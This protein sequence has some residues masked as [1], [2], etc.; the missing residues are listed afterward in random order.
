MA[1]INGQSKTYV[2]TR[3]MNADD[4]LD[5]FEA[6]VKF[7]LEHIVGILSQGMNNHCQFKHEKLIQ[8]RKFDERVDRVDKLH[9]CTPIEQRR[10]SHVLLYCH[11]VF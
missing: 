6:R 1:E 4:D 5:A 8:S 7:D 9:G 11:T 10:L 3:D 2:A